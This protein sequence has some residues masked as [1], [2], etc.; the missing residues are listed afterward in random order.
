M[1]GDEKHRPL[2]PPSGQ[3]GLL[4][5][6]LL[7][8][9]FKRRFNLLHPKTKKKWRGESLLKADNLIA[10]I[11]TSTIVER[12]NCEHLDILALGAVGGGHFG[13]AAVFITVSREEYTTTV[14]HGYLH[15]NLMDGLY[16]LAMYY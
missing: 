10:H 1:T 9:C 11:C 5:G 12:Q 13:E 4:L 3:L 15:Q 7:L 16:C 2:P 6:D 14:E 8:L